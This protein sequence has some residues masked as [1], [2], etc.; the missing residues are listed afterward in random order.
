M[1]ISH[2][3]IP[4]ESQSQVLESVGPGLTVSVLQK[5]RTR[6]TMTT[7]AAKNRHSSKVD[8]ALVREGCITRLIK[9]QNKKKLT[10]KLS[11]RKL[12]ELPVQS[13]S[14]ALTL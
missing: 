8:E 7:I 12:V 6:H 3:Q 11:E 10:C 1:K 13:K 5:D 2:Y 14:E 9:V 4:A